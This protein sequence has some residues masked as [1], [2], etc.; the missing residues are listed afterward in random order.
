MAEHSSWRRRI[1]RVYSRWLLQSPARLSIFGFGILIGLGTGLLMLPEASNTGRLAF[2]DA[3]FTA[4]SASCVTGL[5]VVDTG[6]AFTR[7]GQ[8]VILVLIQFGGLGI[9][10]ISTVALMAAGRKP[11]LT[12][13]FVI[14]DTY[15]HS[16]ERKVTTIVKDVVLFTM[17]IEL[18]GAVFLFF[19]FYGRKGAGEA[20]Y[21]AVFHS[22]SAFCNAG[23]ALF[24]DSFSAYRQD[25]IVNFT[26]CFLIITGGIGFLVLSEVRR[27]FP[28]NRRT[29]S[30][31]SLHTRL[32]ISATVIL[33]SVS[34]LLLAAMEWKNTLAG[35]PI[36]GR[37][38]AAFFQA[39]SA[40][41]AGFNTLP[42]G[43]MANESLFFLCLLMF[44]GA[45]PGSCGGGIK[46]TTLASLS[47]LGIARLKGLARPQVFYRSISQASMGK[48]ISVA[49]LGTLVVVT[50]TLLILVTELGETSHTLS[51]GMF[52]DY[53]FETMSAFGTVG[54]STGV[55]STLSATGR[56]VITAVM[57][58][59]RLGPLVIA[60]AVSRQVAA[61]HYYAEENII[62][63]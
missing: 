34:T 37:F 11:G 2:I 54:L 55:T 57:F 43:D 23:F 38:L 35:L 42:V 52:L 59:G 53:L 62:I 48:A 39:V 22:V 16:G 3:L 51:R 44:I 7:F 26:I 9:M 50:G 15:T 60:V 12:G 31:L 28:R 5:V 30:R 58:V 17:V 21:S 4:T 8:L 61:R 49:M 10:T 14:Q 27:S 25:W 1:V 40:R 41:T 56:L 36:P 33:L 20:L 63:G 6:S 13:R 18:I 46:T 32:V 47:L 24:S 29:W 45:S 19:R